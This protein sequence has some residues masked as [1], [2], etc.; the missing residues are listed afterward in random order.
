[1]VL[2]GMILSL[3][4][5]A[6]VVSVVFAAPVEVAYGGVT[7]F[8]E[9]I[10]ETELGKVTVDGTK[11]TMT[12]CGADIWNN[13]DAFYYMYKPIEGDFTATLKVEVVSDANS[14]AKIGVMLRAS[15]EAGST[16]A[17]VVA[18]N[19]NNLAFQWRPEV[20]G[21]SSHVAGSDPYE[22]GTA[23]YLKLARKGESITGAYS[24]D[25]STW[26]DFELTDEVLLGGKAL[27]GVCHT[28]HDADE[29]G[30]DGIAYDFVVK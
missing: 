22:N 12:G 26:T 25:N 13:A 1:M 17:M 3:I 2:L 5:A 4:M 23:V 7:Y 11:I 14:W 10:G 21:A 30:Q 16:H 28:S 19:Q 20:D 29:V 18:T 6:S 8:A 15:T 9:N 24:F 27:I